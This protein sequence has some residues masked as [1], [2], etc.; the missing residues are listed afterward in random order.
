MQKFLFI[1][2][3]LFTLSFSFLGC[4][5]GG[6]E[7]NGGNGN[8]GGNSPSITLSKN[9]LEFDSND[10]F[11]TIIVTSSGEWEVS[12]G[13]DWCDISPSKGKTGETVKIHVDAN[14]TSNDRTVTYTF[15]C[16]NQ[17]AKLTVLQYGI[18]ETSYVDLK[19]ED[20]DTSIE[21]NEQTGQAT[22]EYK[23]GTIPTVGEGQAFVLDEKYGHDIRKITH[24]TLSNGKLVLQTEQG[25]MC[26]LFKNVSF[27]LTT[28]PDLMAKARNSGR[29]IT[30]TSIE[31]VTGDKRTVLFDKSA[32]SSRDVYT[33][34]S[35][36][37]HFNQDL[38]GMSLFM[39]ED[40][41]SGEFKWEKW[42]ANIGLDGVFQFEFGEKAIGKTTTGELKNFKYYLQGN[43][44]IDLLLAMEAEADVFNFS[45]P[46]DKETIKKDILPVISIKFMVGL[47]PIII[48]LET[49]LNREGEISCSG[50]VKTNA[51]FSFHADAKLGM[52]YD[53][54]TRE[55]RL[56]KEF[57]PQFELYKPQ[58]DIQASLEAA[59]GYYP[60]LQFHF[61][62]FVGPYLDIKPLYTAEIKAGM[63]YDQENEA[64]G[65]SAEIGTKINGELG[66]ELDW[67]LDEAKLKFF[68]ETLKE[69]TL[70]QAPAS[71]SL[72]SPENGHQMNVG[73][74]VEICFHVQAKNYLTG[75][76]YD[77]PSALVHFG[78]EEFIERSNVSSNMAIADNE[79]KV[80]I[81]W[82]TSRDTDYITAKIYKPDGELI[83]KV[84]F[85]PEIKDIKRAILEMIYKQT[86]GDHWN[87]NENWMSDKPLHHWKG[88]EIGIKDTLWIN[89]SENNLKGSI[90]IS[91]I[92]GF[93]KS[94]YPKSF[95]L[96]VNGNQLTSINV[97]G[98]NIINLDC[99]NEQLTS[100]NVSGCTALEELYCSNNQLTSLNASGCTALKKLSCSDNQL[101]SLNISGTALEE[102]YCSNNQLTSL[103][104]SGCTALKELYCRNN[105]LT[106]LNVSGCTVLEE[107]YCNNNKITSV[108]PDWFSQLY[109]FSYDQRYTNYWWQNIYWD[110]HLIDRVL[111]YDDKGVGWWYPG[112]PSKGYHG[113]N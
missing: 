44:D 46:E 13:S 112:E 29:V 70:F 7:T 50:V 18:I 110:G 60:H 14:T 33:N 63:H 88:V 87:N 85:D 68:D 1:L 55:A 94:E 90:D 9:E 24:V 16:G 79:G 96:S 26:D 61:Y 49:D 101:T 113:R 15:K 102:L 35:K 107:L 3:S 69:T 54:R 91:T 11:Q 57:N 17:N 97:S 21:F 56:I 32:L 104:A 92:E 59:A 77:C 36:I 99:N 28:N 25:T 41:I 52:E 84:K 74:E 5:D 80:R 38:S 23:S 4:S 48:T 72:E 31:M 78:L 8:S 67:G 66:L 34:P 51:G 100:L 73:D 75:D 65:W 43:V 40:R 105:Q 64:I 27:T 93:D 86:D 81:N 10:G 89:L 109:Y 53:V 58:Y 39:Q 76:L 22:I 37:F 82:R 19:L 6:D 95:K 30:P 2:V 62:K 98:H 45:I 12:G 108:I 20:K 83:D 42:K 103:N 47:V 71:I 106:S 111:H